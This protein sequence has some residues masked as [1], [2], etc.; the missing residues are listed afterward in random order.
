MTN[1]FTIDGVEIPYDLTWTRIAISLSGGADSALLAYLVCSLV[2]DHSNQPITVHII[3]HTRMWKT[4]PWQEFD[5]LYVLNWLQK[6]FPNIEFERHTGFIAPELEWG[7]KGPT[8]TD[9]YGKLVSGDN[10]QQRAFAEYICFH[11]NVDVY[12]NAV[13]K[14]PIGTDFHGLPTRDVEASD[15]NKHLTIMTHMGRLACHPFRFTEKSWVMKQYVRL[16]IEQLRDITRSCEGEFPELNYKTYTPGQYVP[17]CGECFWCK[18]R[19]W[20]IEQSK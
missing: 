16:G 17:T 9:E 15:E 13:T 19:E 8:M 2:Q 4:K 6:Q 11:K 3:S 7:S 14:N 5:S 12:F 18:E 20:A 1:F 10:I